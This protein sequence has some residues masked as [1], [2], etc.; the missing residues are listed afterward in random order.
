MN[1]ATKTD[2]IEISPTRTQH[3]LIHAGIAFTRYERSGLPRRTQRHAD[4]APWRTEIEYKSL[5]DGGETIG[6]DVTI[7]RGGRIEVGLLGDTD[8]H[9]AALLSQALQAAGI[10]AIQ[11]QSGDRDW[12]TGEVVA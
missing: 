4:Q 1:A 8:H 10:L 11:L 5:S 12:T 2:H 3:T 6:V 7:W 9:G